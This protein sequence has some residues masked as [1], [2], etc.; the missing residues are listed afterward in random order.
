MY[1]L[2]GLLIMS[3]LPVGIHMGF[4]LAGD[5]NNETATTWM[6]SLGQRAEE[7]DAKK[8]FH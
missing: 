8:H 2:S 6:L 3:L 5:D 4:N 1:A 7:L